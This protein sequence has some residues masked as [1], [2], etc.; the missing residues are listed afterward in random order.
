MVGVINYKTLAAFISKPAANITYPKD[1]EGKRVGTMEGAP[2]DL[3]Y[4]VLVGQNKLDKGKVTEIPT[5]W[6]MVGFINDDYDVYP[7][8]I[9]DEPITLRRKGIN[10]NVLKPNDFGVDFIGT[11]Y[12]CR[13]DLIKENPK[14]VQAFV[15]LMA[16]GW[17]AVLD[18]P[19]KAIDVL[20]RYDPSLDIEKERESLI[21]GLDYY[22]GEDGKVLYT[23]KQSWDKMARQ[24]IDNGIVT[25]FDYWKTVNNGFVNWYHKNEKSN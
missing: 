23:S 12:F 15:D 17:S 20:A 24:L 8:F 9:N 19:S 25:S 11:V 2:V 10:S 13:S 16:K 5:N 6:T 4:K 14:K 22:T 18:D 1:F 3:V 21:V 7:A